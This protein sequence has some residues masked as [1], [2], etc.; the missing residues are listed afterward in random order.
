MTD[1]C[2][3]NK[4]YPINHMKLYGKVYHGDYTYFKNDKRSQIDLALTNNSGRK[5]IASFEVVSTNWHISDH[6]PIALKVNIQSKIRC[7][8]LLI[9]AATVPKT[10]T[11]SST[12]FCV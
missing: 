11:V 6:R 4:I 8:A 9:R 2:N 5:C 7:E 1:V 12:K 10:L 3:T